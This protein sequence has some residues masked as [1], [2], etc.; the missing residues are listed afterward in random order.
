MTS[1]QFITCEQCGK[2]YEGNEIGK[3][4]ICGDCKVD[5][6]TDDHEK[7]AILKEK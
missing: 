4:W 1:E 7:K 2:L 3:H 5:K 6:K